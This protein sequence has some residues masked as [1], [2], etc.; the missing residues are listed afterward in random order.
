MSISASRL[1]FA[2]ATTAAVAAVV[3]LAL[4]Q[5]LGTRRPPEIAP[6]V[7]GD[8]GLTPPT[9]V[10]NYVDEPKFPDVCRDPD[11]ML[12]AIRDAILEQNGGRPVRCSAGVSSDPALGAT[13]NVSCT[14]PAAGSSDCPEVYRARVWAER[15]TSATADYQLL[16]FGWM[17]RS[18]ENSAFQSNRSELSTGSSAAIHSITDRCR[19]S[20]R[21][22]RRP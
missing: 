2:M 13:L 21:L 9:Q 11:A 6:D 4:S 15:R 17:Q 3:T 10:L 12:T 22:P 1:Y 18:C 8:I 14:I 19:S 7:P 16:G 20:R 5:N